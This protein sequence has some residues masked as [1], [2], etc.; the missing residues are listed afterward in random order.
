[1]G[2]RFLRLARSERC[3][4]EG[5]DWLTK[6]PA[7]VSIPNSGINKH[8]LRAVTSG[9][10]KFRIINIYTIQVEFEPAVFAQPDQLPLAR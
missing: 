6:H 2:I 7:T 8:L 4:G 9:S 5:E 1:M 3:A 10:P